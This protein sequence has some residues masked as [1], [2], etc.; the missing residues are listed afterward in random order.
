MQ[1][2]ASRH[3]TRIWTA[4]IVKIERGYIHSRAP[5]FNTIGLLS[6]VAIAR[7]AAQ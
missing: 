6:R 4:G 1:T 7:S 2:S 3:H 5:A